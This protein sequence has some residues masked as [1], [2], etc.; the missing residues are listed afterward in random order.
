MRA[1]SAGRRPDSSLVPLSMPLYA[2]TTFFSA[3]LLFVVQPIMAK[4]ILPWFGGSA[5]VWTTCLVFSQTTLLL[6][7]AYSDGVVRKL[8]ARTQVRLH[9]TLLAL[10]CLLL[11]IVPAAHWKP[12]G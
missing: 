10:S 11:P 9:V 6:G 3:V 1:A 8:G 4:Q 7:Y 12:L 5:S 2:A